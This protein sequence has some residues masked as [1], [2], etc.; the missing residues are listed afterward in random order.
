MPPALREVS[1]QI[2]GGMK[3]GIVGRTGSGKSS[4]LYALLRLV[5]L[6]DGGNGSIS[7][8]GQDITHLGLHELRRGITVIPQTPFLFK[9]TIR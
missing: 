5:D 6:S 7:I 1:F 8:D 3:V 4:I 9:G 2:K